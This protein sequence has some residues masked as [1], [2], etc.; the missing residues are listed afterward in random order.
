M[1]QCTKKFAAQFDDPSCGDLVKL[2]ESHRSYL[3]AV[4][5]CLFLLDD[6]KVI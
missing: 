6:G 3:D 1:Q 5:D 2:V 4:E